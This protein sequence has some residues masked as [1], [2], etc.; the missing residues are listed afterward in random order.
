MMGAC[1]A[2]EKNDVAKKGESPAPGIDTG[3]GEPTSVK[4]FRKHAR[5]LAELGREEELE[6]GS[7]EAFQK[8]FGPLLDNLLIAAKAA[9]LQRLRDEQRK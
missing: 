9:R 4:L 3:P 8:H 2:K 6:G 5:K 1:V 7:A